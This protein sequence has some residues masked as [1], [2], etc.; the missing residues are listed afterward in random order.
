MGRVEVAKASEVA[1][2]QIKKF[3]IG[4]RDVAVANIGGQY[5]AFDDTCTHAGASLSE[6]RADGCR[7][8]CGWHGAEFDC[9]TGKLEKFPAKIA[10]LRSYA[11]SV[12]SGSVL[13]EV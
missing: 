2:G 11:A 12:E 3:S 1:E 8:V 7:V 4:G 10:D 13:V 5:Y 9:K 6:G